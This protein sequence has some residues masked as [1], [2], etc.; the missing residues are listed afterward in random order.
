M[1]RGVRG[2]TPIIRDCARNWNS[3]YLVNFQS[4]ITWQFVFY[5]GSSFFPSIVEGLADHFL[6]LGRVFRLVNF[7]FRDLIRIGHSVV[8]SYKMY[9]H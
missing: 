1:G 6:P 7:S 2:F 3:V 8:L 9:E 5:T 4:V